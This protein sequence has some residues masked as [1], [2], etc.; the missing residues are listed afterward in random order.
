M[1]IKVTL[2]LC[3]VDRIFVSVSEFLFI[4]HCSSIRHSFLREIIRCS[5]SPKFAKFEKS[6]A[7]NLKVKDEISSLM[8]NS[9]ISIK[10]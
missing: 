8:K 10:Y 3:S 6:R 7:K 1:T 9:K 5:S 4:F 2:L